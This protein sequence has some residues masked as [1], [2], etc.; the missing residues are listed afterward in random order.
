MTKQASLEIECPQ[1]HAKQE[2]RVWE[3]INVDVSPDLKG[4]LFNGEINVFMC[5][6][7]AHIEPLSVPLLYHDMLRKFLVWYCPPSSLNDEAFLSYFTEQGELNT[8]D[9]PDAPKGSFPEYERIHVVFDMSE[10]LRYIMFRERV[11]EKWQEHKGD[12][13]DIDAQ[14]KRPTM[15][16]SDWEA[17][18]LVRS[19]SDQLVQAASFK[20]MLRDAVI[21]ALRIIRKALEE[22]S[23]EPEGA[24]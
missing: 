8:A 22:L 6:T 16:E 18:A 23:Q 17:A 15:A 13:S 10:L 5:T 11:H 12:V 7:C 20:P 9:M 3:S 24:A 19:A 1:C 2:I 14:E 4:K 21:E